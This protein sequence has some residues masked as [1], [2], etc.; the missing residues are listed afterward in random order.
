MLP[1]A[2]SAIHNLRRTLQLAPQQLAVLQGVHDANAALASRKLS[3]HAVAVLP[4]QR[5]E[6]RWEQG[7]VTDCGVQLR[8][9]AC[10]LA[11]MQAV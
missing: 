4:R 7:L 6:G 1:P 10:S 3:Q 5:C 8:R 9:V 2:A 11:A